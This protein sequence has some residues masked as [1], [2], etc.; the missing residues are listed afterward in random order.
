MLFRSSRCRFYKWHKYHRRLP[1][2]NLWQSGNP[3]WANRG[4]C[5]LYTSTSLPTVQM[6]KR[7][8]CPPFRKHRLNIY[9]FAAIFLACLLYTSQSHNRY[10]QQ[11]LLSWTSGHPENIR[12]SALSL[13]LFY[14]YTP[15]S[16]THLDVYKRQHPNC[17]QNPAFARFCQQP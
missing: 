16:Y 9:L 5:L 2:W 11:R 7:S 14:R 8:R 12:Q 15:V 3:Y 1:H 4:T 10:N 6:E 13:T 17:R